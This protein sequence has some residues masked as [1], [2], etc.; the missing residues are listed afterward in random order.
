MLE[1]QPKYT[2]LETSEIPETRSIQET[3]LIQETNIDCK[4]GIRVTMIQMLP[5]PVSSGNVIPPHDGPIATTTR[6]TVTIQIHALQDI[7]II[8]GICTDNPWTLSQS[9]EKK[10]P[11]R[12]IKNTFCLLRT[13]IAK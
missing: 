6:G 3:R 12:D 11:L 9:V 5:V 2:T 13:S 4:S 1:S 8:D 10:S 7:W